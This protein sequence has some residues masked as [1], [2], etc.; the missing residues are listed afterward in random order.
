MDIHKKII[1]VALATGFLTVI[2][3]A[4]AFASTL[5]VDVAVGTYHE[6]RIKVT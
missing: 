1:P 2:G 6:D 5:K 4:N 3:G